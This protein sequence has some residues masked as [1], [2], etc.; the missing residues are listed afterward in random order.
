MNND[1]VKSQEGQ[2]VS[3]LNLLIRETYLIYL[4]NRCPRDAEEKLLRINSFYGKVLYDVAFSIEPELIQFSD[5]GFR[6]SDESMFQGA[7]YLYRKWKKAGLSEAA[8][9]YCQ[10][11]NRLLDNK[12][13][14]TGPKEKVSLPDYAIHH[15]T[16]L[17]R[18]EQ[19]RLSSASLRGAFAH[20]EL[21]RI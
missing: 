20:P 9:N 7:L 5:M 6:E 8:L 21:S 18:I 19:I 1:N 14:L 3:F 17:R 12:I 4:K 15:E 11:I 10:Y 16:I 2:L 13:L